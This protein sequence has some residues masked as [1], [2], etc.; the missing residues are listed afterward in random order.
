MAKDQSEIYL[1]GGCFWGTE[2]FLKQI[3]GVK[4]TQVGF[5]NGNTLAPTYEDVCKKGTGHAETVKVVY[6]KA[7]APLEFIL[8]LYYKTID[9]SSLNRQGHDVGAQYRTGIYY[10][11]EADIAVI[12]S[13][14]AELEKRIG[15]A[16]T[17][18]ILPLNNFFPAEDYHQDYLGSNPGGYCHIDPSLFALAKSATPPR[19]AL[20]S[21]MMPL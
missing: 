14:V 11:D 16:V 13:S 2:H 21:P 4:E 9:P 18:E 8:D 12:K 20:Q 3:R 6:D 17:I 5:A 1:A 15:T 10:T 19:R 7:I